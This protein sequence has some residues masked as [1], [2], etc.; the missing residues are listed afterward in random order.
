ML[1]CAHIG[2]RETNSFSHND[3]SY[4]TLDPGL[5]TF[6]RHR[7]EIEQFGEVIKLKQQT[8]VDRELLVS[9]LRKQY[10]GFEMTEIVEKHIEALNQPNTFTITTAHQPSLFTGPLYY[11]Y[12]I[13]SVINLVEQL[14]EHYPSYQFVPIFWTGGEDHDFEEINH[15]KIFREQLVWENDESGSVGQM[16]TA[17]IQ[18]LI[19]QLEAV[20]GTSEHA[21]SILRILRKVF[22]KN[23]TYGRAALELTHEL[24]KDKGLVVI[25][26]SASYFKKVA[27]P[28]FKKELLEFPSESLVLKAQEQLV[29]AGF[30][31]QAHPRKINLFYLGNGFRERIIHEEGMYKVLNTDISFG[32]ETLMKEL[33]EHPERFSPNVVLRPLYQEVLLPNLAYIGGGGELAYWLERLEQFDVFG[34]PYP[35]LIRRDS[36]LWIDKSSKKK[37]DKIQLELDDIWNPAQQLIQERAKATLDE[38]LELV[39]EKQQLESLYQIILD[40]AKKVDPTLKAAV[41]GEMKR[42]LKS[43]DGIAHKFVKAEKRKNDTTNQQIMALKDKLFPK[44]NLQER[45]DNFIPFYLKYG[46]VYF[47]T[48]FRHLNPLDRRVKVIIEK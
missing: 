34:I 15:V 9:G 23:E 40:K 48:L 18:E 11:I 46:K 13:V 24:F 45:K 1:E 2:F 47:E 39:T 31:A 27:I 21:D 17:P 43:L 44:G 29:R 5:K 20:L 22:T 42:T 33:E 6:Y 37:M 3:T 8:I 28:L 12:K 4:V 35:M 32:Q 41:E 30:K 10:E 26:A 25:D 38:S 19:D 7:P 36:V 14:E 16:K